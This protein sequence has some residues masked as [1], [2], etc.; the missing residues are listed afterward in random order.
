MRPEGSCADGA[1]R[2]L[3]AAAFRLTQFEVS[4]VAYQACVAEGC[5]EPDVATVPPWNSAAVQSLP[6]IVSYPLA[7]A[8]CQ[9]YGGD[10]PTDVQWDHAAA[11]DDPDGYG[12]A[13]LTAAWLTCHYGGGSN[14]VCGE[15]AVAVPNNP[16]PG[17]SF[18]LIAVGSNAWDTGPYGHND[19]YGNAEEWVRSSVVEESDGLCTLPDFSP[20]PL[21]SEPERQGQQDVRQL[22][23]LLLQPAAMDHSMDLEDRVFFP[24]QV[25]PPAQPASY[26]GFRC[27]F[28]T[29]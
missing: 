21:S 4:N 19:L 27:A 6:V 23:E 17:P 1:P 18:S 7:R 26:S 14:D 9:H 12:I 24:Y 20:D 2:H 10:L 15:L 5:A 8:F 25:R 28:P 16:G 13:S 29:P 3:W 22:G 11:G